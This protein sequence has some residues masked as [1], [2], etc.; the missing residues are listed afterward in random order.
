L[1]LH[2]GGPLLDGVAG[3]LS[4]A[5]LIVILRAPVR[6]LNAVNLSIVGFGGRFLP[7][8][9]TPADRR[10]VVMVLAVAAAERGADCSNASGERRARAI[11]R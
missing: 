8:A 1:P 3:V 9:P 5:N 4:E 2:L 10:F 7:G 6:M 11:S